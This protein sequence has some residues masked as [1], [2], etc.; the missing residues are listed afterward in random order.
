MSSITIYL[1]N[2][3]G[4]PLSGQDVKLRRAGLSNFGVDYLTM[5]DVAGKPGKYETTEEY[6]TDRYKVWVNGSEDRSFGGPDGLEITKQSD[7]LLKSGGTMT[8]NIAMGGNK[9]TGLGNAVDNGDALSKGFGDTTYLSKSGGTMAGNIGMDGNKMTGL[10]NATADGDAMSKQAVEQK[11]VDEDFAKRTAQNI[12]T[13]PNTFSDQTSFSTYPPLCDVD[14]TNDHHLARRAWIISQINNAAVPYQESVNVI[15][16][17]PEGSDQTNK[18]YNTWAKASNAA[19]LLASDLRRMT[20]DIRGAG[21]A[22]ATIVPNDGGISGNN[23][24]NSYVAY[25]GIN[26][27]ILLELS[28]TASMSVY[29]GTSLI[30][31]L[32]FLC[33][34]EDAVIAFNGFIFNNI[35]FDIR[36]STS[37]QFANCEFR[38]CIIKIQEGTTTYTTSKGSGVTTNTDLPATIQGW[39]GINVNDM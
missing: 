37:V 31:D 19:R 35:F 23:A 16:L 10:G 4:V 22:G 38:N 1:T 9:V 14:P 24:F 30:S 17:M 15:R 29:V 12:F 34:D 2:S 7:I 6:V 39:G 25:K 20:V 27:N 36:N 13:E 3:L 21:T 28:G 18:V 5:Y 11:L 32:T 8:G 33:T 26:Q